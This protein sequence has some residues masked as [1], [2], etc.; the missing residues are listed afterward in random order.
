MSNRDKI[1]YKKYFRDINNLKLC[2]SESHFLNKLFEEEQFRN[3]A[4]RKKYYEKNFNFI[5]A[6]KIRLGFDPL[7]KEVFLEY[8]SVKDVLARMFQS[9][10]NVS[11]YLQTDSITEAL[12]YDG[13]GKW[14]GDFFTGNI[15]KK[16]AASIPT[17]QRS[18]P[19]LLIG[20]YRE[21]PFKCE[22]ER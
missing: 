11:Q 5:S 12:K 10:Y 6:K 4:T 7:G 20:L 9:Q 18:L 14:F 15:Y 22:R 3:T 1:N 17:D 21:E 19:P 8:N 16:I 13:F 2:F